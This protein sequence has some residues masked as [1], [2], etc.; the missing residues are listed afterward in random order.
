M[1]TPAIFDAAALAPP[2]TTVWPSLTPTGGIEAL[3]SAQIVFRMGNAVLQFPN[4]TNSNPCNRISAKRKGGPPMEAARLGKYR[5]MK[6][7]RP[8]FRARGTLSR[9]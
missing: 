9:F 8:P 5:E 2:G 3:H 1:R 6:A 4:A 7:G